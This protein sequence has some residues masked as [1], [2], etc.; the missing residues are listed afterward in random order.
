MESMQSMVL[1]KSGK[2][3]KDKTAKDDEAS[4]HRKFEKS[5]FSQLGQ[6]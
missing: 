4:M 6:D 3:G 5:H 1:E 2:G